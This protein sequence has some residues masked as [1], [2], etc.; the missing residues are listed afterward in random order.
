MTTLFIQ[1][2]D[3]WLFRDG[4]PFSAGDDHRAESL[5]PPFPSTVYGALR[6]FIAAQKGLLSQPG[7]I[8]Q[9]DPDVAGLTMR[10]PV[11]A[12]R[13]ATGAF[14]R[15]YP[16]PAN[17][18]P[19]AQ[20]YQAL[21][22]S[23]PTT[24]KTSLSHRKG[25]A[26]NPPPHVEQINLT[27]VLYDPPPDSDEHKPEPGEWLS[28]ESFKSFWQAAN[29]I[30][31]GTRNSDLF[32]PEGR[33]GIG[34][35]LAQRTVKEGRLYE[36]QFIR[37]SPHLGLLV[38][39]S[40]PFAWPARGVLQLGG[41]QRAATF[42]KVEA[43][44][45]P[46]R[47]RSGGPFA[48]Y[49]LTPARFTEGWQPTHGDWSSIFGAPVDLQC[50]ALPRYLSVGGFDLAK[51]DHKSAH[52]YVPAG[53]VYFFNHPSK[54]SLAFTAFTEHDATTGLGQA[55]ITFKEQK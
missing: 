11:V 24:G 49:L 47:A 43:E 12:G 13:D 2:M 44:V 7:E 45:V 27:Q 17:G 23:A 29:P 34:L 22:P 46:P 15:Y 10:G 6:S 20:G 40:G 33:F 25:S 30:V 51:G 19:R 8:I 37:P 4:R 28:E 55:V 18:A 26:N 53:A 1:S 50:V 5:F 9:A 14:T 3:V 35:E 54:A 21:W 36:V 41:E 38:E 42:E 31:P 39:V 16:A 48:V 52:R 32:E